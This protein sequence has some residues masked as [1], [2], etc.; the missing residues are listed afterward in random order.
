MH[1]DTLDLCPVE[2]THAPVQNQ[3][4]FG[5]IQTHSQGRRDSGSGHSD[6]GGHQHAPCTSF[7][8]FALP[9]SGHCGAPA[10]APQEA[11]VQIRVYDRDHRD[12][13][14]WDDRED[15]AYRGFLT[16]RRGTYREY[17]R[18]NHKRRGSTGIGATNIPI[19]INRDE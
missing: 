19:T 12:Y 7:R 2:H 4:E 9:G 3:T 1:A 17:N 10:A 8:G 6:F 14:N 11:N 13:H 16:E 15:R 5:R 18:Q